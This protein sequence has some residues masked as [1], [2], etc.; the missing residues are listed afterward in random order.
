VL[1]SVFFAS[2]AAALIYQSGWQR[3]LT[4]HAGMDL[5]SVTTV[6]AAFMAG[7]GLGNLL[8]G[9]LADRVDA[10]ASV[11]L[12]A[13]MEL[14]IGAFGALSVQLL[15]RLY[16][17][18]SSLIS[19]TPRQFAF[20]FALLLIPTT[21][22]GTT[23]PLL[24]RGVV[25]RS[26]EISPSVGRLYGVNTL[27]AAVGAFAMAGPWILGRVGLQGAIGIAAG[28][29]VVAGLLALRLA[30]I[31]NSAAA[32]AKSGA[33][34]PNAG[35]P[36]WATIYA[37][38]GFA[39]LGLEVAWFRLLN[40]VGRS[41][42]YTFSRLL[43]VYLVGLGMGSLLGG[44]LA[45]RLTRPARTFLLLQ[46]A[47][48]LAALVG[49]LL[50]TA[51]FEHA[52]G[53]RRVFPRDVLAPLVVL[54]PPTVLMGICFP[55]MNRVVS[56]RLE[57]LG[58]RTGALLFANTLGCVL[59]TLT[60]GFFFLRVFGTAATLRLLAG[61]LCLLAVAALLAEGGR[62][63]G[64]VV[65]VAGAFG[66]LAWLLPS[67]VA[68]W[69]PLH[70]APP[71]LMTAREDGSCVLGLF[72]ERPQF[73]GLYVAGVRQNAVPFDE[74]HVRLGAMPALIHPA[75]RRALVIGLGMGSTPHGLAVD[76]RVEH[77]TCV[78]ICAGEL[79]LLESMYR[80]GMR[81][82]EPLLSS[83]RLDYRFEDGRKF[84]LDSG[85]RFDLVVTDTL[86]P[87]S[88]FS[89]SLYS[90]EFYQLVRSRLRVSGVF[91]QWV[92]SR[93]ILETA[94]S[95]FPFVY[96][97]QDPS[98]PAST[99]F[100]VASDRPIKFDRSALLERNRGADRTTLP[101]ETRRDLE[102]FLARAVA[103]PVLDRDF[104]PDQL[105][106]DLFPRDEFSSW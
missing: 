95:V 7:L 44:R 34:L 49:P 55:V 43:F 93:R 40:V 2:G 88:P 22:M 45:R 94:A 35:F 27:G 100:L 15:Q 54:L 72:E 86:L 38:T 99:K 32:P 58:R 78:E 81:E 3:I 90:R 96:V 97:I 26:A 101:P 23:L 64:R 57:T 1:Y 102:E 28:L 25:A 16:P 104:A 17:W 85:E 52:G 83:P 75:P 91:A 98:S 70:G 84:L 20:H 76:P 51:Y 63:V 29:N 77:A 10:R 79:A 80:K 62:V 14:F 105:N 61:V 47:I 74:F 87:L 5:Y 89:G 92:P 12:Y 53:K 73:F 82:L 8:G 42:T 103:T 18:F 37:L 67:G 19:T 11:L 4:L 33:S 39:A 21:M 46:A 60:T 36:L 9:A 24:A 30:T 50:V 6:I 66:V 106:T 41:T 48:G 69:A 68:F 65:G 59:G 71:K 56:N 13:L 31:R